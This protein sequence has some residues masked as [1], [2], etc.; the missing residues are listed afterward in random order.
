VR[1]DIYMSLG[2]KG[3]TTVI[4]LTPE[5]CADSDRV[6]KKSPGSEPTTTLLTSV[7]RDNSAR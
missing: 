7:E 2:V 5:V 4:I 3:L 6:L 1:Y